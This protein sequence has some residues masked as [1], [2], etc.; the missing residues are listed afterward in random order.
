MENT[1]LI[2]LSRQTTLRRE[3]TSVANNI[4]NMNTQAYK[5][6]SMMF[7]DYLVRSDGG[8]RIMGDKLM[9]VRDVAQY[10]D[11]SEGKFDETG[12]PL[13]VAIHGE[14]YFVVDT[15]EGNRYTRNGHFQLNSN[16]VL[17]NTDGHPVLTEDGDQIQTTPGDTR[18]EISRNGE[19]HTDAG[20]V[21]KLGIV[22]FDNP[23]ELEKVSS[24][25]MKSDAAG[26]QVENP[27]VHQGKLEMSNVEPI[28]EMTRMIEVHRAYNRAKSMID[29]EDERIRKANT[30]ITG[31]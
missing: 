5:R 12:N 9:F 29:K 19:I 23:Q 13:D 6:E 31:Q 16:G 24:T 25:L 3:M 21:G 10:R 7:D 20:P 15:P 11:L 30:L 22:Q 8:E 1:L 26:V 27:D 17:V 14:G 18:F 2:A 4:A 28:I